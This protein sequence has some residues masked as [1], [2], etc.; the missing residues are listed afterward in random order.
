[1]QKCN[2]LKNSTFFSRIGV[3]LYLFLA[4]LETYILAPL[5][6]MLLL[7]FDCWGRA[8]SQLFR[9]RTIRNGL[10]TD[11]YGRSLHEFTCFWSFLFEKVVTCDR[12]TRKSPSWRASPAPPILHIFT[13]FI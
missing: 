13:S 12:K 9:S 7:T 1:M 4:V 11:L 6:R 8:S 10:R 2:I 5:V 3:R